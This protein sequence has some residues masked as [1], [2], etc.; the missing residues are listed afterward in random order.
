MI[1]I[2][3]TQLRNAKYLN[4][5]SK[6]ICKWK[7][8][9]GRNPQNHLSLGNCKLKQQWN[10]PTHLLEWVRSK[11]CTIKIPAKDAA[12]SL[13]VEA[14]WYKHFRRWLVSFLQS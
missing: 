13:L 9:T 6:K 5:L 11:K 4:T 14:L 1:I 7:I 3:T 8:N 12:H 10:T 2:P